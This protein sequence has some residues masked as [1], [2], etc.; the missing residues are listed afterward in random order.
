MTYC[1]KWDNIEPKVKWSFSKLFNHFHQVVSTKTKKL[2]TRS[3]LMV[4]DVNNVRL[5]PLSAHKDLPV[6]RF[7]I[8][9]PVQ[10]VCSTFTKA[11]LN[12]YVTSTIFW[13]FNSDHCN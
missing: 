11:L 9:R 12:F 7:Q 8:V 5:D 6:F 4:W 13:D 3:F 1:L 2:N 10:M